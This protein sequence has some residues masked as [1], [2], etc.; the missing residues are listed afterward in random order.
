M[1][2]EPQRDIERELRA[3]AK[4]RREAGGG[5]RPLP[6]EMRKSLHDE[7]SRL[8]AERANATN[9]PSSPEAGNSGNRVTLWQLLLGTWQRMAMTGAV[10]CL[11]LGLVGLAITMA[12]RNE[13]SYD[14]AGNEY[15]FPGA[16]AKIPGGPASPAPADKAASSA[17][18]APVE[19][20]RSLK[21][22]DTLSLNIDA[23]TEEPVAAP[24]PAAGRTSSLEAE[25]RTDVVTPTNLVLAT[26]P[27]AAAP[28]V[29]APEPAPVVTA[30]ET[31][32]SLSQTNGPITNQFAQANADVLYA[33]RAVK[34]PSTNGVLQSF[35]LEQKGDL[36]RVVDSDGSVYAGYVEKLGGPATTSGDFASTKFSS[37]TATDRERS[38]GAQMA[39]EAVG[40][41]GG[42]K[43]E[44]LASFAAKD[45]LKATT[46]NNR[47]FRISGTNLTLGKE[48]IFR[49]QLIVQGT[50]TSA[51]GAVTA[52]ST[53]APLTNAMVQGRLTIGATNQ[54]DISARAG[55]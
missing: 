26:V 52:D 9:P 21:L 1:S 45:A 24:T 16:R 10:A 55:R 35:Q 11:F 27:V 53:L 30:S 12:W 7:V 8:Q 13:P 50:T 6:P 25:T 34:I 5:P 23:P 38:F 19:E 32:E 20:K 36:I 39:K 28:P 15:K 48:L 37:S 17:R 41:G 51:A 3:A 14:L 4:L 22:R 31:I 43:S 40:I 49:G 46:G 29:L 33:R 44:S 47:F 2:T 42:R 18:V 54:M